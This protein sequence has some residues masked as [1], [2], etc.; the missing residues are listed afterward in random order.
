MIEYKKECVKGRPHEAQREA[1]FTTRVEDLCS[2]IPIRS[3]PHKSGFLE[4]AVPDP[5]V[6]FLFL[7]EN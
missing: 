7:S 4:Q 5:T 1:V 2:Y 3:T 6:V